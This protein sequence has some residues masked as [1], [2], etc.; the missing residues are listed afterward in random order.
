[1]TENFLAILFSGIFVAAASG[2]V[3]SFL[4]MRRMALMSDA[5]SHVA[6]PGIALGVI[7]HFQP[8][9]GGLLFLFLGILLIWSVEK[10]TSLA[11]ES[12][13]GVLFVTSLAVGAL[14]IPEGELLEAFFGSVENL[15]TFQIFFQTVISAAIIVIVLSNLKK[16]TLISIAPE[17]A[18]ASRISENS[19]ELLLLALIALTITIGIGF[20]G[21]LLI[22]A[23]SIVPAATARNLSGNFK[24]FLILSVVLAVISL[25]GG[26]IGSQFATIGPGILTVLISA[27]L[28]VIS[29]LV[30]RS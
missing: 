30:K 21:V 5:L 14:L 22:S 12:V 16:I 26:L 13:T 23:L 28:F 6:L 10:K 19:M 11:I 18:A 24:T 1:M 4:V 15:T 25:S 9:A 20:V 2:L 17:L 7:F 3:G 29:L 8:L 27:G